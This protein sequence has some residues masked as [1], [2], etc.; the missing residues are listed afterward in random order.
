M[1]PK[2]VYALGSFCHLSVDADTAINMLSTARSPVRPD[3]TFVF[4]LTGSVVCVSLLY[5]VTAAV[6]TKMLPSGT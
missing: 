2:M 1:F 4:I 5:S 3:S 6:F